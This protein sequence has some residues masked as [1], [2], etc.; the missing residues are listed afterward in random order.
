MAAFTI[1]SDFGAQE[2][3]VCQCGEVPKDSGFEGQWELITGI[4]QDWGNRNSTLEGHTQI[5][6]TSRPEKKCQVLVT[7]AMKLKDACSLKEKLRLP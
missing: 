6:C 1:H 7:A 3:E 5:L 4:P 2:N